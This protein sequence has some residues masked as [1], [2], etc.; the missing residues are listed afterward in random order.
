MDK[1]SGLPRFKMPFELGLF[2]G[3]KVF[4]TK[5]QKEKS[6]IILDKERF[7]YQK[8]I[9]DIS[10]QDLNEH[11]DNSI[12][13]ISI[14]RNWLNLLPESNNIIIQGGNSMYKKLFTFNVRITYYL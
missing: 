1:T 10:G 7:R 2:H 8:F 9:S 13:I 11:K 6:Y 14:I 3:A 4:G 5:K 12:G